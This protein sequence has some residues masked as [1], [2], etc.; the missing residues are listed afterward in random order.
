MYYSH[1]SSKLC[2]V[3][4]FFY[5]TISTTD[6]KYFK[7]FKEISIA[8]STIRNSLTCKFRLTWTT[9]LSWIS[10][11]SYYHCLCLIFSISS[12]HNLY[13]TRKIETLNV[14]SCYF[15]SKSLCL[16]YHSS[17]QRW[18]SCILY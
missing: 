3:H 1:L 18:T 8:R 15:T 10:S 17:R 14:T 2:K 12:L 4:S 11:C 13:I 9:H 7:I 16:F 5:C 6:Y